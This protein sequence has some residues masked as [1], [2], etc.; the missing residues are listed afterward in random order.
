MRFGLERLYQLLEAEGQ[1]EKETMVV[2][3]ARGAKEDAELE[4]EF[5]RVCD[6]LSSLN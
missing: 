3:E 4:L 2:F 5:R 1:H 6:G